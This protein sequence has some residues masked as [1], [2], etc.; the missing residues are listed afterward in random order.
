MRVDAT[1]AP[2]WLVLLCSLRVLPV[3]V[4]TP[5]LGSMPVPA[6][7][8]GMIV[9]TLAAAMAGLAGEAALPLPTD[10]LSLAV[11]ALTEF[12]IGGIMSIGIHAVF[13]AIAL[14]GR[15]ID[16]QAGFGMGSVFDPL[17]KRAASVMESALGM[18]CIVVF[19]SLD[20]HL[21][22]LRM[23]AESLHSMPLGSGAFDI[24][25]GELIRRSSVLFSL[26]LAFAGPVVM[27]MFLFDLGLAVMSR[28][29]PQLQVVFL[30]LGIKLAVAIAFVATLAV[31]WGD[32]FRRL[33]LMMT[34]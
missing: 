9:L 15:M 19:F 14:A 33:F 10:P 26:G 30:G 32:G 4:L 31:T 23:L 28:S 1:L 7:L 17:T 3:L 13:G 21:V 22:L 6:L 27:L 25:L 2:L 5:L 8:K 24:D 11:L 20:M 34:L 16:L 29:V 12:A 18:L